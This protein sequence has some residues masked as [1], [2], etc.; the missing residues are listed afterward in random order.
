MRAAWF[1][2]RGDI[3]VEEVPDP[4]VRPGTPAGGR[5]RGAVDELTGGRGADVTFDCAGVDQVLA[6]A[7]RSTRAG[8]TCVNVAI[9]GHEARV[10]MNDLVFREVSVLGSLAYAHDH[11]ATI[12]MVASGRVDPFQF[13]TGRI[14]L[15]GI[16]GEGLREL[17]DSKE[18][19]VE[20]LVQPGDDL[21]GSSPAPGPLLVQPTTTSHCRMVQPFTSPWTT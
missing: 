4:Q 17:I 10:A 15:D 18:Q 19:N 9:W 11:P 16:V 20:I 6:T 5:R 13:I 12:E 1:R 7:I 21:T 14:G 2:G 8:G 3:R